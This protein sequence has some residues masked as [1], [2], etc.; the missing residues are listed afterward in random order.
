MQRFRGG[1]VFKAHGLCASL[2]SRFESNKEE[3]E[4]NPAVLSASRFSRKWG[5]DPQSYEYSTYKTVAARIWS[6]LSVYYLLVL[7]SQLPWKL[8]TYYLLLPIK[9]LSRRF[10]EGFNFLK[11]FN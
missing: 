5:V 3:Q 2:D 10:C 8:S 9:I 6:W 7:E 1:V 4:K 11:L